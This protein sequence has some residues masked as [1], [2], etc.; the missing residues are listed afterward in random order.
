[1]A[2]FNRFSR[3]RTGCRNKKICGNCVYNQH[4]A[5]VG[6]YICANE[7]SDAYGCE[8]GY[9]DSCTEH[10]YIEQCCNAFKDDLRVSFY[11]MI[12]CCDIATKSIYDTFKFVRK[13]LEVMNGNEIGFKHDFPAKNCAMYHENRNGVA[14]CRGLK[15]LE[16]KYG[17]CN[18][19]KDKETFN[20]E[21]NL[22]SANL[23]VDEE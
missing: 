19:F 8:I 9:A 6:E 14:S 18:F 12:N 15:L 13:E 3:V 23:P 22:R 10:E 7:E 20:Y 1:M 17:E 2:E 21:A 16:C 4:D 11:F 5:D